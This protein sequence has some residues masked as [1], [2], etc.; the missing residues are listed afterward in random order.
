MKSSARKKYVASF[1]IN[2]VPFLR[3]SFPQIE[4]AFNTVM[5]QLA[6]GRKNSQTPHPIRKSEKS[7]Y[8]WRRP[9]RRENW[10]ISL[11]KN[12]P[13]FVVTVSHRT[14]RGSLR[15]CA[16]EGFWYRAVKGTFSTWKERL[17]WQKFLVNSDCVVKQSINFFQSVLKILNRVV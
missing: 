6:R 12:P 17:R 11:K 3:S 14:K 4:E 2:V 9:K 16:S 10:E 13:L 5:S 1:A 15:R 8:I 7:C